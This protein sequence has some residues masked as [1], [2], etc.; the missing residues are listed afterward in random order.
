MSSNRPQSFSS[1][2]DPTADGGRTGREV[3]FRLDLSESDIPQIF[4]VIASTDCSPTTEVLPYEELDKDFSNDSDYSLDILPNF[5]NKPF[6]SVEFP[7][8]FPPQQNQLCDTPANMS[9]CRS[10]A[11]IPFDVPGVFTEVFT[12]GFP[13][14]TFNNGSSFESILSSPMP[15]VCKDH[16]RL[17][18]DISSPAF[19]NNSLKREF[20]E[21]TN[22]EPA[23]KRVKQ[24]RGRPRLHTFSDAGRSNDQS[25]ARQNRRLPHNQVERKYR[26]SLNAE[27]E[28][29]RRVV[30]TL[31]QGD[32][33]DLTSPP[34]PTK[35][36]ILASAINYIKL[37][38]AE[39]DRLQ[40]E[41]KFLRGM[42]PSSVPRRS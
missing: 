11:S 17:S 13:F 41:N 19:T 18:L 24:K 7:S 23:P 5:F 34:K 22:E 37:I 9:Q 40:E 33:T 26:E 31:P 21:P 3:P 15:S 25:K 4:P 27:L 16:L 42:R 28:R 8:T 20:P 2:L 6:N 1:S 10:F 38:E 29:L 39:R 14:R 30:P 32:S 12:N 35:A 36:T